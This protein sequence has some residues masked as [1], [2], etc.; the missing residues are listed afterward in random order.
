MKLFFTRYWLTRSF[1]FITLLLVV[2][3]LIFTFATS[4]TKV[5]KEV[6]LKSINYAVTGISIPDHLEFAGEKVPLNYFDVREA[7]DRELLVNTYWQS[8]TMLLLKRSA[9]Y[10]EGIETM[11]KKENIPE[12]FK[13]LALAE[14]GLTNVTSPTGAVGFWQFEP[15]TAREYGLEI[16]S[17]VDERYNLQK[18]TEAACNFFKHSFTIYKSWTMAAASFNMGRKALGK[19]VQRQLTNNYYDLLLNDET[20]RYIYRILALKLIL[21][22][23]QYYG[24][25]VTKEDYYQPIP[26][27]EVTINQSVKDLAQYSYNTGTNYK[28][29]KLLNPWLRDNSLTIKDGNNYIIRIPSSSY[30]ESGVALKKE[31]LEIIANKSEDSV[32]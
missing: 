8:Q 11:L 26:F 29:L 12:D 17:E 14:S 9:R 2:I 23:P 25:N 15:S 24:F 21:S 6:V 5:E 28:L 27:T 7:L 32:K 1:I 31:D 16:N 10:F 22:N 20:S 18:S 13:Y 4:S 3:I 19:Q 30:R